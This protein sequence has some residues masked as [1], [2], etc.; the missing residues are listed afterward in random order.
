MLRERQNL[1]NSFNMFLFEWVC[2]SMRY[3]ILA[4]HHQ[5]FC[6]TCPISWWTQKQGSQHWH[7]QVSSFW[8]PLPVYY[9]INHHTNHHINHHILVGGLDHFLFSHILGMS[10]SQLTNLFQRGFGSATKQYKSPY[11][12]R[13]NPLQTSINHQ[14]WDFQTTN[15]YKS[16]V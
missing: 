15:Q 3:Q 16:P 1:T 14:I 4:L 12:C 2:M 13:V 7:S 8:V 11:I 9:H 6:F 5:F 10:S